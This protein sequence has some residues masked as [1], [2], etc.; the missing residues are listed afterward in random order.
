MVDEITVYR[1]ITPRYLQQFM[2]LYN[3]LPRQC[4]GTE[5][6]MEGRKERK[7]TK[8]ERKK[9]EMLFVS[10]ASDLYKSDAGESPKRKQT[11]F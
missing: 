6:E 8:K 2:Y 5:R 1:K 7:E 10:P 3:P 11:T 9:K 4:T